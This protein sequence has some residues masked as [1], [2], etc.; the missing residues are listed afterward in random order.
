MAKVKKENQAAAHQAVADQEP[1]SMPE[2]IDEPGPIMA[3][4]PIRVEFPRDRL[5]DLYVARVAKAETVSTM[6]RDP[7]VIFREAFLEAR[8]ALDIYRQETGEGRKVV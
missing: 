3:E 5:F 2:K 7:R 6:R 8:V 1:A 4:Q